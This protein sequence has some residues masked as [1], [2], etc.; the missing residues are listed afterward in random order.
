MLNTLTG[1]LGTALLAAPAEPIE[2]L[3]DAT[4]TLVP[5]GSESDRVGAE[6]GPF[7]ASMACHHT[8]IVTLG[9]I[10]FAGP[11]VDVLAKTSEH[12]DAPGR[13]EHSSPGARLVGALTGCP[14]HPSACIDA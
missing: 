10:V 12:I 14:R 3:V 6:V 9:E 8:V 7:V 5:I 11:M 13:S 1:A 4:H 2:R